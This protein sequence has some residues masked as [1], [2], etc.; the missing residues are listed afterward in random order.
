MLNLV[1]FGA[2]PYSNLVLNAI[3]KDP[4]FNLTAVVTK[5]DKP[6]GRK[7][8]LTA[9]PVAQ[10]AQKLKL[11][12]I[13][14][15]IFDTDFIA[16][17]KSLK[18]E[19]ALVLGYGPPFFTKEMIDVPKYKIVNIHPSPL[20]RYRGATPG[21]WQIINGENTSALSFFVIDELPDHGPLITQI[22]FNINQNETADTFYQKAFSL[23]AANTSKVL[24]KYITQPQKLTAQDHSQKSYYPKITK[25]QAQINW[26]WSQDKIDRFIQALIPW[27][28]AWTYVLDSSNKKLKMKMYP[29]GF[30]QIEGKNKT[31]WSQIK[32]YYQIVKNC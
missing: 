5:P 22:P 11:N 32:D 30:V 29:N 31:N 12:T 10:L 18:P 13:K 15:E 6:F 19:L 28:I 25:D 14:T 27:P 3:A 17:F 7:Q 2:S 21:P 1:F 26:S 16:K 23:A 24:K 4:D 20:P 8:I 9:N